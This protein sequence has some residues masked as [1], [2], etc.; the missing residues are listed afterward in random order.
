MKNNSAIVYLDAPP[1]ARSIYY[2]NDYSSYM[3]YSLTA[4]PLTKI[5]HFDNQCH[6]LAATWEASRDNKYFEFLL[7]DDLYWSNGK[8]IK[9]EDYYKT[10]KMILSDTHNRYRSMLSDIL[11]YGSTDHDEIQGIEYTDKTIIFKLKQSNYFFPMLL[12]FPVFS[13]LDTSGSENISGGSYFIDSLNN[14]TARLK[15]NRYFKIN[16]KNSSIDEIVFKYKKNNTDPFVLDAFDK[17]EVD[18]TCDTAFPYDKYS[19]YLN[20]NE[21]LEESD[22]GII[23][24]LTANKS[25]SRPITKAIVHGI[26]RTEIVRRLNNAPSINCGFHTIFVKE[27]NAKKDTL[28]NKDK[29]FELLSKNSCVDVITIA[30]ENFYPNYE[31]LTIIESQLSAFGLRFKFIEEE[32]GVRDAITHYRLSLRK[33]PVPD[34]LLF[35]KNEIKNIMNTIEKLNFSNLLKEYQSVSDAYLRKKVAIEMDAI[36]INS[37]HY[38][39]ILKIPGI[40]LKNPR[41]KNNDLFSPGQLWYL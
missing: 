1:L 21:Y 40:Y 34:P 2:I 26:D 33:S 7:S 23:C 13:P 4:L 3:I 24:M 14:E 11:G 18:V 28:H 17:G 5:N 20:H 35:Y 39:P 19:H 38:V 36:L 32:Y 25:A 6:G 16:S 30:Y 29:A 15:R 10:F 41:I 8:K 37:G 9:A 31:I 12:S 27:P 22:T